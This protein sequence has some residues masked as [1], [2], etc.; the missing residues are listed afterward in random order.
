VDPDNIE[1]IRGWTTPKNVSKV[2][3][4][5]GYYKRFIASFSKIVHPITYLQKKEN[6]F[7]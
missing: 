1:A 4:L 2:M 7:E 6:K 3:R 5:D